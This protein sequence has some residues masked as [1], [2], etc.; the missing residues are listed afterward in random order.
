MRVLGI[1]QEAS[2]TGSVRAF[3]DALPVLRDLASDLIV[4]NKSPGPMSADLANASD[5]LLEAPRPLTSQLRRMARL[6]AF[7]R[8][9]PLVERSIARS[10]IKQVRP[11]FIYASTVLSSEYVS[12]AQVLQIPVVLHVHEAQPLSGWALKRSGVDVQTVPMLAPSDFVADELRQMGGKSIAVLRGPAS[13][14]DT[15]DTAASVDDLPWTA[16]SLRVIACGSV[17]PWKGTAEWLSAAEALPEVNGRTVE[18]TW[19]GSG[20]QLEELR[21]ETKKRGLSDRAHWIGERKDVRPYLA[22]ADLFAL[23]SR[24]EPLGLVVLEASSVGVASIAFH[25]GGV[26]EILVDDRALAEAGNLSDF[27]DKIRLA[28]GSPELRQEL[29]Q[30]SEPVQLE[31]NLATWRNHLASIVSSALPSA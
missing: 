29:L 8:W 22:S 24:C 19:I 31:S 9:V 15:S 20:D 27:V 17:A 14:P 5:T 3:L 6:R 10:V 28:L 4:V 18:W 16:D 1:T 11:D 13:P 30:A 25:A 12:V 23:P 7:D 26:P 2:R 21:I